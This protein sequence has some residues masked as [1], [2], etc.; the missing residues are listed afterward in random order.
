[1]TK[2]RTDSN[3]NRVTEGKQSAVHLDMIVGWELKGQE[4]AVDSIKLMNKGFEWLAVV[5]GDHADGPVIAFVSGD[6]AV[7]T[8]NSLVNKS[9]A[10]GL[11]WRPDEWKRKRLAQSE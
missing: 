8:L 5:S 4:V 10:T 2:G 9:R 6:T 1:M 3:G 11:K 7:S